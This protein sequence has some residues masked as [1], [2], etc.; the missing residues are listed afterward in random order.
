[1]PTELPDSLTPVTKEDLISAMWKAWMGYFGSVPKK[2]SIWV[3]V[4]QILLETGLKY[5]HNFNLGNAKSKDGDGYDYQFFGCGEE[6]SLAT[7]NAW[8]AKDPTLVTIKRVYEAKGKQMASVWVDPPHWVSRFR[9]FHDIVEGATD[10]TALLVKRF[11]IAW[12][13]IEKG[14]PALFGHL[15]KQQGYY[16]D[17][18]AHYTKTLVGTYTSISKLAFDYDSLPAL[19]E[20]E[21]ERIGS[22]M[23]LSLYQSIGEYLDGD[24]PASD[25]ESNA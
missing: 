7:A 11:N 3:I 5:C 14:D 25:D 16:T 10:H 6:V 2:E 17:D 18:E 13:G 19:T 22:L 23:S 12:E 9:A 15:L 8:K 1:M 20:E 24:E 4:G 21:K